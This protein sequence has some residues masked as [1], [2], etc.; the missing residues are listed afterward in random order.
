[1]RALKRVE[2]SLLSEPAASVAV[3]PADAP[4]LPVEW[5]ATLTVLHVE[6]R[7]EEFF[8]V[9]STSAIL[10]DGFCR[11]ARDAGY[12]VREIKTTTRTPTDIKRRIALEPSPKWAALEQP[13][14]EF[15]DPNPLSIARP[16]ARV[17]P[18]ASKRGNRP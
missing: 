10:P 6:K 16:R 15:F 13:T 1:M 17:F 18:L 14:P 4:V 9:H 3:L 8:G 7:T 5:R 11:W 2:L 12:G